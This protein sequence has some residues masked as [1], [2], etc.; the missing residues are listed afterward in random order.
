MT[1][2][3]E[4]I[5]AKARKLAQMTE[6]NGASEA[7]AA[8]AAQ[9]LAGLKAEWD[10]GETEFTVRQDAQAMGVEELISFDDT[11]LDWVS[12]RKAINKLFNTQYHSRSAQED[13]LGLGFTQSVEYI[14]FFGLPND[15][16]AARS[17]AAIC[18]SAIN[19]GAIAYGKQAKTTAK[20]NLASFRVGMSDRLAARILE[21]IVPPK[22]GT[23]LMVLKD[24]LVTDAFRQ[25]LLDNK[26]GGRG[27]N[28]TQVVN[29]AAYAAGQAQGARVNLGLSPAL[30]GTRQLRHS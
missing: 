5:L 23:G 12:C 18:Q 7:E 19:N 3:R 30:V 27:T 24:Q 28:G 22:T 11:R 8:K 26:L 6:A 21:L 20:K 2:N 17:L 9:V 13:L 10:L 1:P 4:A 14:I 29:G 25:Y 15:A 16:V